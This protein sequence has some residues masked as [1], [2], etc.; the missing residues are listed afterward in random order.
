[1][2]L[3]IPILIVVNL[4]KENISTIGT[5]IKAKKFDIFIFRR[6]WSDFQVVFYINYADNV[7]LKGKVYLW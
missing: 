5:D 4:W 2:E 7:T 6:V 3:F 1:M